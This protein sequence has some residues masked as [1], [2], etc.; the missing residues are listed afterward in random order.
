MLR[1]GITGGIGSGKT[2]VTDW[3]A[4]KGITIV[5]ADVVA[6]LVVAQGTPA[7]TEIAH[8]FGAEYLLPDGQLDRAALRQLVFADES[9]RKVLEAITHPKI[10]EELATQLR[11]AKS[12]YVVLSS[13]LLLEGNQSE[14]VDITVVVDV[15]ESLQIE[16]TMARDQNDE[17]LVTKIM[18]AQCDRETRL[19]RADIVIDN[20]ES[21]DTLH[22]RTDALHQTLLARAH[23]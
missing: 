3:L 9:K 22:H 16:R 14:M 4:Q 11:N 8:T 19:S 12:P 18:A 15:P 6:R 21:L 13:P 23:H 20:S 10:R 1:V 17:A 7:L 2:A 5:D